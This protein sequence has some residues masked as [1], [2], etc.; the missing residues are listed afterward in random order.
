MVTQGRYIFNNMK[1]IL[2]ASRFQTVSAIVER[3][4]KIMIGYRLI[5][6]ESL[7]LKWES[8]LVSHMQVDKFVELVQ[9][10]DVDMLKEQENGGYQMYRLQ[11]D[12]DIEDS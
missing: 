8:V 5:E 1:E 3:V 7:G 11:N 9:N 6:Y 12:H 10:Q 4:K 2:N